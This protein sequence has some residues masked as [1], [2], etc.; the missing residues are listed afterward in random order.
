MWM[1]IIHLD[2]IVFFFSLLTFCQSRVIDVSAQKWEMREATHGHS[3]AWHFSECPRLPEAIVDSGM[4]GECKM[5]RAVMYFSH[6]PTDTSF[7]ASQIKFSRSFQTPFFKIKTHSS[8]LHTD[9][10]SDHLNQ[11]ELIFISPCVGNTLNT[12]DL[13]AHMKW[14]IMFLHH[15]L[16]SHLRMPTIFLQKCGLNILAGPRGFIKSG[17]P[18]LETLTETRRCWSVFS[19]R[20]DC[21]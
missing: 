9:G 1:T 10:F 18:D 4:K 11:E 2:I 5:K 21:R 13:A 20:F 14:N 6:A 7:T 16:K 12:L 15:P 19:P 17:H 3:V 8:V